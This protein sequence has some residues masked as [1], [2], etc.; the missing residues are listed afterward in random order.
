MKYEYN[1]EKE[2]FIREDGLGKKF[3]INITEARRII[4]LHDLGNT[5]SE[6]RNKI[7]FQS[8]KVSES[9]IN[10]FINQVEKGNIDL[11]GDYPAPSNVIFDLTLEER[12]DNIEEAINRIEEELEGLK[13]SKN[14]VSWL[15]RI[16]L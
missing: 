10:N 3:H 5:I 2:A 9:T 11:N 15:R 13:S 8:N 16:G 1:I 12:I 14:N 4:T 6:I 7:Q